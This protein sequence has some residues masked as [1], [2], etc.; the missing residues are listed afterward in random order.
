MKEYDAAEAG[1][2]LILQEDLEQIAALADKSGDWKNRTFLISGATGLIGSVLIKAL[3]YVERRDKLNIRIIGLIRD[4]EKANKVFAPCLYRPNL[5]FVTADL[6]R[7]I[8]EIDGTIDY[9]IHTASVTESETMVKRPVDTIK[10]SVNGT[11][12]LLELARRKNVKSMI[13]LS[14]MEVYGTPF[15]NPH[16]REG[17]LGQ[18]PLDQVRSCYPESKR[19][20]ECLCLS[21]ASQYGVNVVSARLA[22]TFGAGVQKNDNR[23]YAQFARA[24]INRKNIVLHTTGQSEGNYCYLSDAVRAILI[25]LKKGRRGEAY[26]ISNERCHTTIEGMAKMVASEVAKGAIAVEYDLPDDLSK[27]G[28]APEVKI[29]LNA[30]GM[31]ELG[32]EPQIDLK[33]S[34]ERLILSMKLQNREGGQ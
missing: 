2:D 27:Y 4:K 22:Q 17:D 23:V 32:W 25:L 5:E 8:P 14:S 10:T 15:G 29:K 9:I 30:S 33:E 20:C 1:E 3:L 31:R 6:S 19:M 11:M 34:Y 7:G 18:I 28:Y 12:A 16:V 24:V 13:Y 21:Y 26:N